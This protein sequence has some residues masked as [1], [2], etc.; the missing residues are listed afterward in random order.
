M[1]RAV[2]AGKFFFGALP[3]VGLFA[4]HGTLLQSLA[5]LQFH[6]KI[7][8]K[9]PCRLMARIFFRLACAVLSAFYFITIFLYAILLAS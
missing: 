9:N 2:L 3:A 8:I 4:V 1:R 6:S 5:R 7:L